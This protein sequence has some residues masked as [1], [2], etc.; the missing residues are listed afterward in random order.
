MYTLTGMLLVRLLYRN[1]ERKAIDVIDRGMENALTSIAH[2]RRK[3]NNKT[4]NK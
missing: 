2:E 1:G 3:S 4:R